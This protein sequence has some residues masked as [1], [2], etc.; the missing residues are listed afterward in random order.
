MKLNNIVLHN[1]RR[2]QHSRFNFHSNFTV[3]VG[4]NGTGKTSVLDA[5]AIAINTYFQGSGL[6]TGGGVIK[7]QDAKYKYVN[8]EEQIYKE[9]ESEVYIEANCTIR[10]Q[11]LT[12]RRDIGDRGG[13]AKN[14]VQ[15]GVMDREAINSGKG[16]DLPLLL[17]YGSGR[18]WNVHRNIDTV[19]PASQLDAYKYSLDPNSDQKGFEKWFKQLTLSSLQRNI[20]I[21]A[22]DVVKKAI[23]SSIPG[24][25]EFYFDVREDQV[26]IELEKE[27]IVPFN[28]LSDGYRNM[29]AM[30]AD[31]AH[32]AAKLNP[33]LKND[34]ALKTQ[35]IILIDEIDLHLHP[36]WQRRVVCDLQ[37]AFP[38]MQFVATTHSPFIIQSLLAGNLIDLEQNN[39]PELLEHLPVGLA[40]PSPSNEFSNR[41]IED[42]VE[43]IMSIPMPQRSERYK[44]MYEA[45]AEYYSVLAQAGNAGGEKLET[46]KNRLD[47]L[48]EPFSDNIA[49]HAFL[50]MARIDSGIDK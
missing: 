29:V 30:I 48:S 18:L 43:D 20:T 27:G 50:K 19:T 26:L 1:F 10:G 5:I 8:I 49:Y 7:K 12:W 35:G 28:Y 21:P 39:S 23:I 33:H 15:I 40:A 3:L 11:E 46:L 34:S 14:L 9:V 38:E 31:I 17:Y 4:N 37:R 25:M 13:K 22:L 36:K 24:A 6:S 32:R 41:S 16:H 47:E 44:K 42:I 45:A 2:Y